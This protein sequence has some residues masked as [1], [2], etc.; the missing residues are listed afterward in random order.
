MV[1]F[2]GK[3]IYVL[4]L[5]LL[6]IFGITI[7]YFKT[8]KLS[9][10]E[11]NNISAFEY[12]KE[13]V[14]GTKPHSTVTASA[15]VSSITVNY[16]D[17]YTVCKDEVITSKTVNGMTMDGV[18]EQER[19]YQEENGLL[20][21]IFSETED[22]VT[23]KRK[24]KGNCPNHFYVIYEQNRLNIYTIKG[25]GIH[26]LYTSLDSIN[27]ANIRG[28]LKTMIEKGAVFNSREELNRFIEDLET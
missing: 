27:I 25:E 2:K 23:Y 19:I 21:E 8:I 1:D 6:S 26:E 18:K 5:V 11:I 12:A 22:S 15:N 24:V 10:V 7:G 20:Y 17:Y 9:E 3:I 14:F 16:V 28:E 13:Y 4:C